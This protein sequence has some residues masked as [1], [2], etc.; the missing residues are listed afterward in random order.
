MLNNFSILKSLNL[1]GTNFSTLQV[2]V[3]GKIFACTSTFDDVVFNDFYCT[4]WGCPS[5]AGANVN[6]I[7]SAVVQRH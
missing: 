6:L 3:R 1:E 7:N 5:L 2:F 4:R